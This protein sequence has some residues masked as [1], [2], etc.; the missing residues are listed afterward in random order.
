MAII[1]TLISNFSIA[2]AQEFFFQNI[3]SFESDEDTFYDIVD[4]DSRF[5]DPI[6]IGQASLADSDELLVFVCKSNQ[7]LTARSARKKQ[8]DIAKKVLQE[9]FKDGAIFIFYDENENFR[10]NCRNK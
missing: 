10:F 5:D 8:F 4:G 1:D 7:E 2:Q 6:K 9:D 3:S